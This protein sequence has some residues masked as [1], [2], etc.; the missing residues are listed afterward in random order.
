MRTMANTQEREVLLRVRGLQTHF[1]SRRG[2]IRAVDGVDLDIH[3]GE[4]VGVVGETG[5]GKSVTA[6][7]VMRLVPNPPGEIVGGSIEFDGEDLLRLSA[8]EM[9]RIRGNRIAMI[10]QEPMSALNPVLR[11]RFQIAEALQVHQ[12]MDIRE[13]GERAVELMALMGIPD[14]RKRA[15]DFPHQFSG[16]MAQRVM[17]AMALSCNPELLIADE[18]VT[19]LD[20]TIQAQILD[21]LIEL[22]DEFNSAVWLITHDLG[23]VAETCE[24]VAVMYMGKMVEVAPVE[25]LFKSPKHPYTV[26]LLAS[27]PQMDRPQE[28]L[29]TIPGTVPDPFNL[30]SGCPFHPRCHM[31]RPECSTTDQ[32]LEKVGPDHQAACWVMAEQASSA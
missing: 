2:V 3:R 19:A 12:G 27:I 29:P 32:K 4:I 26:G 23:V 18:P 15:D 8:T 28:D 6:L 16:G 13:A 14:A 5:C 11:V 31:A 20:V 9:R 1:H 7:S 25:E 22:R 10:F 30:P 24:R 17:I 21:L